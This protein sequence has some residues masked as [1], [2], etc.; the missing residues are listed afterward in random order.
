VLIKLTNTKKLALKFSRMF[1]LEEPC[2][3]LKDLLIYR[4]NS[5]ICPNLTRYI[6]KASFNVFDDA[7]FANIKIACEK[8]P[9]LEQLEL[10]FIGDGV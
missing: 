7:E 4:V 10:D 6:K 3:M 2:P 5:E 8:S 9:E 1:R